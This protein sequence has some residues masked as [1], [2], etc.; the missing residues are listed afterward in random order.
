MKD[1]YCSYADAINQQFSKPFDNIYKAG[2]KYHQAK[3]LTCLSNIYRRWYYSALVENTYLTPANLFEALNRQYNR[4][5]DLSYNACI[6]NS[7]RYEGVSFTTSEYNSKSHPAAGDFRAIIEYCRPTVDLTET[8]TLPED[9]AYDAARGLHMKDPNYAVYLLALAMEMGFLVKIPSIHVNRAQLARDIEKRMAVSDHELFSKIV[10]ATLKYASR[11]LSE[12]I[13][14]PQPLFDRDYLLGILKEPVE[15]DLIF[16]Q[17]YDVIGVDIEDIMSL[18]IFEEL[19]ML[20][21]A[22]ISGTYLLGILLDKFF[23]TP[24]GH[25]LKLIRP[26]YLLPFDLKNE[27]SV[28]LDAHIDEDELGIAFYAPCSRYYLTELGLEFFKV[29]ANS[30]NY[31]EIEKKLPFLDI[32]ALFDKKNRIT[33]SNIHAAATAFDL[34]FT[35]YTLKVKHMSNPRLWLN[36]EISDATNLHRLYLELAYYFDLEKNGEYTFFPDESENPFAAYTSPNQ[37]KRS[38]KTTDITVDTLNLEEKTVMVL[39]LNYPRGG[40]ARYKEKW[41]LEVIKVDSGKPGYSYPAVVRLSKGLK[42]YFE[43]S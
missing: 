37:N 18:D 16:Q 22:V 5:P 21:M 34:E 40:G 9:L 14:L 33:L 39:V 2:G 1:S 3:L 35:A 20:D 10:S 23:L 11:S 31:L 36:V 27:I 8:D 25:Y 17:L 13:P 28:Y 29:N 19:D 38:K 24:F 26:I 41:S 7:S 32:E 6:N 30:A 43:W 15:S 42:E 4:S 12:L